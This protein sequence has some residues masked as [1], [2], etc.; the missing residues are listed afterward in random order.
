MAGKNTSKS[1]RIKQAR[2]WEKKEAHS[3]GQPTQQSGSVQGDGDAK[4]YAG[5]REIRV[6][7]KDRGQRKSF[8][9]SLEEY[10]KGK[11]QG[12]EAFGI[13]IKDDKGTSRTVY[14]VDKDL[15]KE[16]TTNRKGEE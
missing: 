7:L 6:E 1:Q 4:R 15:F 9:L 16:L 3:L 12:V 10:E 14:L 5:D 13:K 8:N 2:K 11:R